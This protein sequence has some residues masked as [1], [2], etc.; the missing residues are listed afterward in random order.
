M[1]VGGAEVQYSQD[2]QPWEG[3]PNV[4]GLPPLQKFSPKNEG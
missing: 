4:G 3:N 1:W 2:P